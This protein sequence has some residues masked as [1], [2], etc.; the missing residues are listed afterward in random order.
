MIIKAFEEGIYGA[1]TYIVYD[2]T[3]LDCAIIDCTCCTKE[4]QEFI[5]EKK[6]NLK[7]ILITHGHF[8]HVYCLDKFKETFKNVPVLINKNDLPLLN[9]VPLQCQMAGVEEIK[10]PSIDKFIDENTDDLYL[11]KNQLQIITTPG[12]SKGGNCYLIE[13]I[14]FCGDTLFQGSIGRYDLFGGSYSELED[15]IVNKL[16]K[17]NEKI[18]VYPGHG[19]STTINEEKK[20]NQYFR[21]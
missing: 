21:A 4:V 3:S 13:D 20:F 1:I 5:T 19:P 16:Y 2:E 12:H 8:D 6:L 14:M 15:S 18:K 17:L 11:G 9:Q 10:V 7:Y